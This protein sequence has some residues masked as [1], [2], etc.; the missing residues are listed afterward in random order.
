MNTWG[1][2]PH[3][4]PRLNDGFITHLLQKGIISYCSS[5]PFS[6]LRAEAHPLPC[7]GASP[8]THTL[9]AAA[10]IMWLRASTTALGGRFGN[11]QTRAGT[12]RLL[13]ILLSQAHREGWQD[14]CSH[15]LTGHYHCAKV[16]EAREGQR[17]RAFDQL[18]PP[19]GAVLPLQLCAQGH[20][21]PHA[22]EQ[23]LSDT[24]AAMQSCF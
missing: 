24:T 20:T 13:G 9:S 12:A 10:R 5:G 15:H 8:T 1:P 2:A 7:L 3:L 18:L 6:F 17:H 21:V 23:Q 14:S 16:G 11:P 19:L 22:L 4:K